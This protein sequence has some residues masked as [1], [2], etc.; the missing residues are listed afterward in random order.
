MKKSLTIG[1]RASKLALA[2][3]EIVRRAIAEAF[4]DVK[5]TIKHI[6]T[7]GDKVRH[8]PLAQVGGRGVFTKEI[9]DA[10]LDGRIDLAVHSLKDLPTSLPDGLVLAAVSKREDPRDVL[11]S[12]GGLRLSELPSGA[13]VGTSSLR[14]RAQLLARRPD[15][16]VRDIRG[17]LDTRLRKLKAGDYDAIVVARAGLLRLGEESVSGKVLPYDIM[18][19]AVGQGALGLE[20]RRNDAFAAECCS[21]VNDAA[22]AAC[23][24]AERAFLAELR[25]GCQV[26]IGAVAEIEGDALTL[27]GMV[28]S[29]DGSRRVAGEERGP[30]PEAARVG[31]RLARRLLAE[32]GEAILRELRRSG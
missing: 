29:T 4:P 27:R 18:L 17:N 10:L 14:R 24:A 1:T 31:E 6:S 25:G 19:P 13:V 3:T 7:T 11:I 9:E 22:T 5:I 8:V 23:A 15:L 12:R 21:V 20:T 16:E 28:C 32:G 26:P 2:Q 30:A